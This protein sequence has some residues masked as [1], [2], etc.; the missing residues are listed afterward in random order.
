MLGS[1]G[2]LP[3]HAPG[4]VSAVER[5]VPERVA[6][7]VAEVRRGRGRQ[8]PRYRLYAPNAEVQAP[9]GDRNQ[10]REAGP[11]ATSFGEAR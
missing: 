9:V 2:M 3:P 8:A 6:L 10:Q 11:H 7:R 4:A 5:L 1:E